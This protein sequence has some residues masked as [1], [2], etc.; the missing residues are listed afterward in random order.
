MHKTIT[1]LLL[2]QYFILPKQQLCLKLG[3]FDNQQED[4]ATHKHK[5]VY[6]SIIYLFFKENR[7]IIK[8]AVRNQ[9]LLTDFE[10]TDLHTIY[11]FKTFYSLLLLRIPAQEKIALT[12]N[13]DNVY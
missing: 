8:R 7:K 4:L 6:K 10:N 3:H 12:T 2:L 9:V 11:V 1:S 5:H 13:Q